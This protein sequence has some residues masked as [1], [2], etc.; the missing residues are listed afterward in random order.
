MEEAQAVVENAIGG[1]NVTTTV[2]GRERYP[3]NVRY[4]R[5]FRS[6]LGALGRVLVPVSGG[7]KQIPLSQLADIRMTKRSFHDPRRGRPAHRLRVRGHRRP[8]PE[9]LHR[10]GGPPAEERGEASPG[11]R[12]FLERRLRGLAAGQGT[13][14]RD[15]ARDPVSDRASSL[16][17]HAVPDQDRAS[18]CWPCLSRPSAPSG[19]ST[20]SATT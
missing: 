18:S 15:R 20:C 8:R 17:E 6:D 5:D 14:D 13:V 1:E 3:V 4:K 11:L 12:H 19:S 16:P 9:R 2:E 10:G 7:Q